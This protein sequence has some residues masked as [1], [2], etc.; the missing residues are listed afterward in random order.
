[1]SSN[2]ISSA[3]SIPIPLNN[4]SEQVSSAP[5]TSTTRVGDINMSNSEASTQ[6]APMSTAISWLRSTHY[7]PKQG[8]TDE[9][10]ARDQAAL[11][12]I[13][14]APIDVNWQKT[15]PNHDYQRAIWW[16]DRCHRCGARWRGC[17]DKTCNQRCFWCSEQ[18]T[19]VCQTSKRIRE[20]YSYLPKQD[21]RAKEGNLSLPIRQRAPKKRSHADVDAGQA[22]PT[23]KRSKGLL[24][25]IH[26]PG[27]NPGDEQQRSRVSSTTSQNV[28]E[29][30]ATA[31]TSSLDQSI[32]K[33]LAEIH[34]ERT[35]QLQND[36]RKQRIEL[37]REYDAELQEG[38]RKTLNENER[39]QEAVNKEVNRRLE[40]DRAVLLQQFES[41]KQHFQEQFTANI[42]AEFQSDVSSIEQA[43]NILSLLKEGS[44]LHEMV[45]QRRQELE[46]QEASDLDLEV[47][48]DQ[49]VV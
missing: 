44:T 4:M 28:M 42:R 25:S 31:T 33:M 30:T 39:F 40:L 49:P 16:L 12:A 10:F 24:G 22:A 18:H 41:Y 35:Q 36:M 3:S 43:N 2:E 46:D 6:N 13:L 7:A 45:T 11:D 48:A 14:T 37:Y 27:N 9:N 5:D 26:N 47:D 19:G 32:Q 38:I 17:T 23:A 21:K 8:A 29:S 1:M 20:L 15:R 34:K